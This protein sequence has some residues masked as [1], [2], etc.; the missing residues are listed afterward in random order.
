MY[1]SSAPHIYMYPPFN[2]SGYRPEVSIL[3]IQF[4]Q[5]YN[6][7]VPLFVCTDVLCEIGSL[8]KFTLYCITYVYLCAALMS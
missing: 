3:L 1:V 8:E 6:M 4:L 7:I 2:E 5:V